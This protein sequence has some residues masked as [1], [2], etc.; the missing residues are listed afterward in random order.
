MFFRLI[1][2]LQR[3]LT[4]PRKTHHQR[5]STVWVILRW[6]SEPPCGRH[7]TRRW[8]SLGYQYL[9]DTWPRRKCAQS[10]SPLAKACNKMRSNWARTEQSTA[11]DHQLVPKFN[12]YS[13]DIAHIVIASRCGRRNV[14]FFHHDIVTMKL[15]DEGVPNEVLIQVL[16][17]RTL[18]RGGGH[19]SVLSVAKASEEARCY[20]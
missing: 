15:L 8:P 20:R 1:R 18:D 7:S 10:S 12:G 9:E 5:F 16:W 4:W 6:T 17:N 19:V 2:V 3:L 11:F 13:K 14:E